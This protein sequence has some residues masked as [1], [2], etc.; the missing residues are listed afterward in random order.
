MGIVSGTRPFPQAGRI[1][2]CSTATGACARVLQKNSCQMRTNRQ[3]DQ[4][5]TVSFSTIPI[6]NSEAA[7]RP[8]RQVVNQ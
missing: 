2:N 4:T 8:Q 6:T 1:R 5:E 3:L 7:I